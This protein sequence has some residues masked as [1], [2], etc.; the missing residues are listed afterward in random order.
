VV[1]DFAAMIYTGI[2]HH[3]RYSV[4]CM[5]DA[6]GPTEAAPGGAERCRA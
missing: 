2:E 1:S 6:Q 5:L 3:K 4:A